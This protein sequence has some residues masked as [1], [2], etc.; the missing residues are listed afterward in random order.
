ME[1]VRKFHNSVKRD[2][3]Q[4]TVKPGQ[5]ALDVGCGFGG[6]LSKWRSAKTG[7]IVMCD[8]NAESVKEAK[9]RAA[10]LGMTNVRF[11]TG[12]ISACPKHTYDVICYNF[13]LQYIFESPG[14]F[15]KTLDEIKRRLKKGGRLIGCIPN[16]DRIILYEN[17][18][19]TFGNYFTRSGTMTGHGGFGEKLFVCLAD[20][21]Y[22]SD[23]PKPEPIAYKDLLVTNLEQRGIHLESWTPFEPRFKIS[24]FYSEFIFVNL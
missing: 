24:S 4:R 11:H 1:E 9:Q 14:L 5:R 20:T 22:Y 23:G 10:N 8:P 16:S 18:S 3:I 17:F 12:D 13:S 19:D 15:F 21:P 6:D 7:T 2:L